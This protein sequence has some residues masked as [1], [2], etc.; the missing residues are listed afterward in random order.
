MPLFPQSTT[1]QQISPV[2]HEQFVWLPRASPPY[3]GDQGSRL[4]S[5]PMIEVPLFQDI[6]PTTTAPILSLSPLTVPNPTGLQSYDEVHALWKT[7]YIISTLNEGATITWLWSQ[8]GTNW[9]ALGTSSL[10]AATVV[11]APTTAPTLT[12]TTV[13]P[14]TAFPAGTYTVGYTFADPI[15]GAP[16]EQETSLSPTATVTLTAGQAISV[17]AITLPTGATTV[18]YYVSQ[19][20]GTTVYF[21]AN[22]NGSAITLTTPPVSTAPTPPATGSVVM[23]PAALAYA[24][25]TPSQ[26]LTYVAAAVQCA[27]L[28]TEGTLN[29]W[30]ECLG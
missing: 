18:N 26:Y 25:S 7:A 12:A 11:S 21:T 15:T 10:A 5:Y 27:T 1:N 13:S 14:A 24:L 3:A 22:G 8:N 19:A 29:G 9:H 2:G 30:V 16:G 23:V 28:P 6:L 20:G 17:S 4:V